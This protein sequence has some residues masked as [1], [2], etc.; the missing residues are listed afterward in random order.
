[1]I[2]STKR[3]GEKFTSIFENLEIKFQCKESGGFT[4]FSL[5]N[6]EKE[7]T[8]IICLIMIA[9]EDL[10]YEV[11][12]R[13]L[14]WDHDEILYI[15]ENFFE[16]GGELTEDAENS[17]YVYQDEADFINIEGF[18]NFRLKKS[19]EET[20]YEL[21]SIYMKTNSSEVFFEAIETFATKKRKER[22]NNEHFND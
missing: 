21:L 11:L 16:L 15:V 8:L 10:L 2:I 1:M 6:Y 18:A 17:F 19:L 13:C 9:C 14:I 3:Y 4:F 12:R 5:T 7:P 20:C 22:E